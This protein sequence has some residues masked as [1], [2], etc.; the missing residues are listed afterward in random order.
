MNASA[1]AKTKSSTISAPTAP[2]NVSVRTPLPPE[3]SPTASASMPVTPTVAPAGAAVRTVV[4]TSLV[5]TSSAK[6]C[7]NG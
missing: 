1:D 5:G 7:G 2:S 4:S 6:L 3:S